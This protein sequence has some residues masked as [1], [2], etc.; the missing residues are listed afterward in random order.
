MCRLTD[1]MCVAYELYF[2]C[3]KLIRSWTI[4]GQLIILPMIVSK[5]ANSF[6][7]VIVVDSI[8]YVVSALLVHC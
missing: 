4:S 5:K 8:C 3:E 2:C 7:N 1:W 6:V